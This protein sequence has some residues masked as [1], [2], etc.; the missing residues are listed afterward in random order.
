MG[1]Q[2][3]VKPKRSLGQNF[4][5]NEELSKRIVNI[6]LESNPKHIT[7][8]GPGKGAFTKAFYE[9]TTEIS[10]VE[11]DLTLSRQ[12]TNTFP[13][14]TVHN[15]D[16][17]D[18]KLTLDNTTYFGSLPFNVSDEIIE[19]VIKSK[20]FNNPAFFII[21]K[22]V[23]ENYQNRDNNLLGLV[24]HIYADVDILFDI[25]AGNF[26]P[27]PNV[28]ASFVKFT[29]NQKYSNVNREELEKLISRSFRQPR[30]TLKNNLKPYSYKIPKELKGKRPHELTL[31][32]YISILEVN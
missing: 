4:F 30:K 9:T 25:K 21:Q 31:D 16:F 14:A 10:L 27:R 32:M 3:R 29:P 2:S 17:L 28:D 11:K 5:N 12:L 26:K 7:E 6:V 8:I 15:I 22:E 24:T 18:F 1:L 23:A 13:K 20:T 19:K